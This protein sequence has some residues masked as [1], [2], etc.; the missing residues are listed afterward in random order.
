MSVLNTLPAPVIQMGHV[1][2]LV[3]VAQNQSTVQQQISQEE[4]QKTLK[5]EA[6]QVAGTDR[7]AQGKKVRAK[8]DEEDGRRQ[9][10]GSG[11]QRDAKK[12]APEEENANKGNPWSGHIVSI[13]I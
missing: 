11:G 6:E 2:K 13:T 8:K 5:A 4:A 12:E 9:Q 3:E 1:E 10:A 7:S